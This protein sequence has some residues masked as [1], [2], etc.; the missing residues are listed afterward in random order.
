MTKANDKKLEMMKFVES[1]NLLKFNELMGR[2]IPYEEYDDKILNKRDYYRNKKDP[3]LVSLKL[4]EKLCKVPSDYSLAN[5]P[6]LTEKRSMQDYHFEYSCEQLREMYKT[7]KVIVDKFYGSFCTSSGVV[8]RT[9][10]YAVA[11]NAA[12]DVPSIYRFSIATN[13]VDDGHYAI[14]MHG[15]VGGKED[16]WLFLGR[17]DS[18]TVEAHKIAGNEYTKHELKNHNA[19]KV[20]YL[21]TVD[22]RL[23]QKARVGNNGSLPDV[24]CIPFPH[25][26]KPSVNYEIGEDIERCLP[27]FMKNCVSNSFQENIAYV[28]KIFNIYNHPHFRKKNELLSDIIKEEKRVTTICDE[29]EAGFI[30]DEIFARKQIEHIVAKHEKKEKESQK[31]N[32]NKSC[33]KKNMY[34][35]N[36]NR[37]LY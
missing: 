29:P 6:V 5:L 13:S 4:T 34:I 19:T 1:N 32:N 25:M 14:S 7:P 3:T 15:I 28:M 23:R 2:D 12:K 9:S 8:E 30:V 22:M 24:Y 17:L 33:D 36:K 18:G 35:Q 21:K 10:F 27:K 37:F 16:G 31:S 11:P 26:H 20:T